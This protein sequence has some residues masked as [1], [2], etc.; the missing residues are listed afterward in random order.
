MSVVIVAEMAHSMSSITIF[1]PSLN[2]R[3]HNGMFSEKKILSM[4]DHCH[5]T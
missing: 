1:S 4:V 5:K 3:R 2:S